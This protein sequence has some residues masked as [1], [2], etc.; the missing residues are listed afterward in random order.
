MD[1]L[2]E[3]TDALFQLGVSFIALGE[4]LAGKRED[5]VMA[6]DHLKKAERNSKQLLGILGLIILE[7][8]SADREAYRAQIYMNIGVATMNMKDPD[9]AIQF[10]E[11]AKKI[12]IRGG[13]KVQ[14]AQAY[15]NL[16]VCYDQKND[17]RKAIEVFLNFL[18]AVK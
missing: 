11:Y 5:F 8:N 7:L 14:E 12:F 2:Q 16:A 3:V 15:A 4:S 9:N 18:I 1:D 6:I 17:T 13:D 10:I